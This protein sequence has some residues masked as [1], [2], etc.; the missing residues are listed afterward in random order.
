MHLPHSLFLSDV[1]GGEPDAVAP[2]VGVLVVAVVLTAL[3]AAFAVNRR[4]MRKFG[5]QCTSSMY[6]NR[7][8]VKTVRWGKAVT[9][10]AA[11]RQPHHVLHHCMPASLLIVAMLYVS[12]SVK[13]FPFLTFRPPASH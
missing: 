4:R 8:G 2:A 3:L 11:A 10:Q 9:Q 5:F 6:R 7:S 12:T 1:L 13:M